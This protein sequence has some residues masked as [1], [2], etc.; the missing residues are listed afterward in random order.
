MKFAFILA[1]LAAFLLQNTTAI[2]CDR[3]PEGF[4]ASKSP[5]DGRFR[6]KIT[7][8]P[9]R[10]APGEVYTITLYG[11]RP[12]QVPQKF[13]G[14][15]IGAEKETDSK[16]QFVSSYRAKTQDVG[17]FQLDTS[18]ALAIFS[19]R[20]PGL[21]QHSSSMPKTEVQVL[22]TAPS[23]GAGC[24]AIRAT[25]IEHRDIWYKDD[26][27]LSKV[28]C[29]D[30]VDSLDSQPAIME[31]CCACD[32]A[33]Y[34]LTFEGLWSRHTHPK[35]FPSNGWLTR[36]SDV[37]GAS[38]TVD[39]RFWDYGRRASDG[40]QQIAEHGS[41]RKLEFEL[42]DESAHIRTIIKARG[43]SYPNVTGKTFAV[44]RVDSSN[45]LVSLV[46]QIDPSPDWFLGVSGLELCLPNCSWVENKVLNL[47]P[48]DAGT[49][50]GPSYISP[51]QPTIPRDAIRRIKTNYPNDVRSPFYDTS[52]NEMKP[53]ARL[54]LNR[55]RI[56][57][58]VCEGGSQEDTADK[59][60]EVTSW[61][62]WSEC[63]AQCS[64]GKR[65]RQRSYI[66]PLAASQAGCKVTLTMRQ[67]C[68]GTN[69]DENFD[70]GAEPD[71]ED[72]ETV[73]PDC[74]LTEWSAWSECSAECG[75]GTKT[76]T[77]KYKNRNAQKKCTKGDPSPPP[78][79]QVEECRS[80]SGCGGDIT[81]EPVS[82]G[83]RGK[84]A[85]ARCRMTPWSD[86]SPCS[87]TCGLGFKVRNR[88]PMH[89]HADLDKF[90]RRVTDLYHRR[91]QDTDNDDDDETKTRVTDPNDP[92]YNEKIID[93]VRCGHDNPPCSGQGL[94]SVPEFCFLEPKV[95]NCRGSINRWY[96]DHHK[97]D[98]KLFPFTECGG[99]KNNFLSREDCLDICARD[100]QHNNLIIRDQIRGDYFER[101]RYDTVP[102]KVDCVVSE[103]KRSACNVTC[104]DGF[105]LKTRTIITQPKNGGR[106]CP[107]KLRKVERCVARCEASNDISSLLQNTNKIANEYSNMECEYSQWSSWTPCSKSCGE[108]AVQQRTRYVLNPAL[109]AFCTHRLEERPCTH[110]M[111]CLLGRK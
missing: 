106:K 54:Y 1:I 62:P 19:S 52:G 77:R 63:S 89:K 79:Q 26:G 29:E 58:K 108:G 4:S 40:L 36:F 70:M 82:V 56:Y 80:D 110:I 59:S 2:R 84:P 43:I 47:Y 35:D 51:K 111:P 10:Y 86:F 6:L 81:P 23:A 33:K 78:L 9:E 74:A 99:N 68:H 27:P 100:N 66:N 65:Y 44:F 57:E 5:A 53:M 42:K 13:I 28:L 97:K 11:T 25:V 98:C 93:E 102:E 30:E 24:I 92:C 31:E 38:H 3:S 34:E 94:Y 15:A 83:Q 104:G 73:D 103:W 49:D 72:M 50:S 45:H 12:L 96:Y 85:N 14:F 46:S 60:C 88:M 69:C 7:G 55:Q 107:A 17:E 87:A 95:G 18:D 75:T 105:R 32:E 64:Q 21:I 76:R 109:A 20:C 39:Y 8:N 41:T 90:H 16:D 91:T 48:I 37:I 101:D 71:D 61:G 67:V 22:W